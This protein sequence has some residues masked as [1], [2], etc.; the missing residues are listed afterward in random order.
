MNGQT[1]DSPRIPRQK[2]AAAPRRQ[3]LGFAGIVVSIM[4]FLSLFSYSSADQAS[5]ELAIVDLWKVFT[6]DDAVAAKAA[7][8]QNLLGLLGA[9]L[10]NWWIN[11]TIGFAVIVVPLLLALWSLHLIVPRNVRRLSMLTAY[12]L[13]LALLFSAFSGTL[14]H[15]DD[16]L[17]LEW[18]G[19]VGHFM[20]HVSISLVGLAGTI[21]LLVAVFLTMVTLMLNIDLKELW[22][23]IQEWSERGTEAVGDRI[24]ALQE[25]REGHRQAEDLA[26]E[27]RRPADELA[28][29]KRAGP[30]TVQKQAVH[31]TDTMPLG[32]TVPAQRPAPAKEIQN[33]AGEDLRLDIQRAV[34]V[35]EVNFDER[36]QGVAV[37]EEIDYVFPSVEL[38]D[39]H[40][41]S[42]DVNEDELKA[43]AELLRSKL[44]DFG[45]AIESVSVTPGP[46]VTLYEL[47]PATG[48]KISKI[49]S[50]QD[51][52]ALALK[53]KGI[54]IIA[55]I[56]GKGTVGVE[57]PNHNPSLVTIRSVI[58]S[59]KF[60]DAKAVL[61]LAVGKTISGEVYVDDLGRLPHILIAGATGSG[62]SVGVNTIIASLIY[63]LHPSDLKF[64]IIDPKKIELSL[65]GRLRKH[66][67]IVSPDI[68]EE[69]VTTPQNAVLL[70]KGL[71]LE[72]ERRYDTLAAAGVRNIADYNERFLQ[73]RLRDTDNVKHRK[74]PF[75]VVIVDELADLMMTAAREV[76]EPIARLAQLAR[77]VGIHL[78]LATQ[79]PSVDVITGVIKA[80]FPA[81][82]AYQVSSKVDSRT[83]LDMNGAEQLLGNGDM[84]YLP[85]GI[86]KPIR[87]QNA[88]ISTDEVERLTTHIGK[89]KGYSTPAT[90]PSV[91]ERKRSGGGSGDGSRDDLFEEAARIIVRHQQG[92]VSLLQRRLK[93]GYSRAARLVDELE[94]AGIVGPFDGSKARQVLCESEA[95]LEAI[96]KSIP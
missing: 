2:S 71:E 24:R 42:E 78:V 29:Q 96:L 21:I 15:L 61:P 33:D 58:N 10:A 30:P 48:V 84:L 57:I 85:P 95:E 47:V 36:E 1:S 68:D 3:L 39:T 44:S 67:L 65:Y 20:A 66:Y 86:S 74:M 27:I 89:Q 31:R 55:P 92:S 26:V 51:D 62:K 7:T 64:A 34:R 32:H 79:R 75:I 41:A 83:I 54:R 23:R 76:E 8:T 5:G 77:A 6:N 60:R 35:E 43:N 70:L 46:V 93:V 40:R 94:M 69:I 17:P 16:S 88:F 90:L 38:L 63:R 4:L 91:L 12:I 14:K 53:A 37:E 45:V 22:H 52:I 82:L 13:A 9:I 25:K 56:P 50:L 28:A 73:G 19:V 80:N 59:A 87:I 72:M 11:S 18:S 49:E 81:R